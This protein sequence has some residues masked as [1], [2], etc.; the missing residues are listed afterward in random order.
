MA[1]TFSWLDHS[2]R[3]RRKVLEALD[4]FKE[5]DT[6]DELGL[7]SIRDGFAD[8][9]FPG[10]SVLMTRARYFLFVPWHYQTIA[11]KRFTD[12][13]A[14][15]RNE[16]LRLIHALGDSKGNIGKE[17]KGTLQRTPSSIYWNGLGQWGVRT[18]DLS[19]SEL[20]EHLAQEDSAR[21]GE[22]SVDDDGEPL[23]VG[24]RAVWDARLPPK[25]E[26]F[27]KTAEL[28]LT[29]DEAAYLRERIRGYRRY[30]LLAWLLEPGHLAE[31]DFAWMHPRV[32]EL[33]IALRCDLEH[34]RRF[35]ET[36]QGA[37]LLYNLMLARAAK[38]EDK[39]AQ[40]EGALSGWGEELAPRSRDFAEWDRAQ[41][42]ARVGDIA[43]V[44]EP[45]R[46]F[47]N[48]WYELRLWDKPGEAA[49]DKAADGLIRTRERALKGPRARLHN[50][51]ALELWGGSSGAARLTYRWPTAYTLAKDI[52]EALHA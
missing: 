30:T 50:T 52:V 33:P 12:V 26:G 17:A 51:R 37:A 1:S 38:S 31:A 45:T 10:T 11:S 29:N 32:G 47:V 43:S 16:E 39:V 20:H 48:H 41:F 14:A 3:E 46:Q 4:R 49:T 6:R 34:A 9:F 18:R 44:G 42:W 22:L 19:Q 2:D 7:A 13:D 28:A 5:S 40:F 36:M 15:V 23:G 24:A 21:H 35:A 8:L 25:P 27:P